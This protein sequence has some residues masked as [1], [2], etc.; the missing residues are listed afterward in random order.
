MN[1]IVS[2]LIISVGTV[3]SGQV[4][5]GTLT[6]SIDNHAVNLEISCETFPNGWSTY[7]SL[8]EGLRDADTNGDGHFFKAT[9]ARGN[10]PVIFH[11]D[12]EVY[13]FG[14]IQLEVDPKNFT[15]SGTMKGKDRSDFEAELTI[16]CDP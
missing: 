15:I 9:L 12:G 16:S 7:R 6:G 2:L 13:K 8:D 5:A 14:F 10:L 1:R 4:S 11:T 3:L